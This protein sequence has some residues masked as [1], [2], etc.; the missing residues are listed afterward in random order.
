M[1]DK[2]LSLL[3]N[4]KT[5]GVA[6]MA[7]GMLGLLTGAKLS[8]LL[9]FGKGAMALEDEWREAHPDFQ[10]GM[11]ERWQRAV[12]DLR[13]LAGAWRRDPTTITTAQYAG[14]VGVPA[15]F[16]RWCFRELNE[17]RGDRGAQLLLQRH[18]DRLVR[19]PMPSAELDIDRPEDL[20]A[21]EENADLKRR[22]APG[23]SDS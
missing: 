3:P 12:D 21:L 18:V 15:I 8:S 23:P 22:P 17:L 16:P 6:M 11:D 13:R 9:M 20:L 5:R 1:L 10:G 4:R 19:L 14:A 7:G 2:V